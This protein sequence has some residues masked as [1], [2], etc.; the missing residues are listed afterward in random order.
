MWCVIQKKQGADS[1]KKAL[2]LLYKTVEV[3][4]KDKGYEIIKA[5]K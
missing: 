1:A 5:T 2:K 3:I 4:E